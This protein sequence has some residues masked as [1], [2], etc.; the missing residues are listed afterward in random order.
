MVLLLYFFM[1]KL[2]P[3]FSEAA[4]DLE[5]KRSQSILWFILPLMLAGTGV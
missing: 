4:Y 5:V 3:S 2:S 1:E